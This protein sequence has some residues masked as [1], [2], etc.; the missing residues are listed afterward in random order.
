MA[1]TGTI[2]AFTGVGDP[3]ELGDFEVPDPAP[4]AAVLKMRLANI[5]GSDMHFWR[6]TTERSKGGVPLPCTLGHEGVGEVLKLGEGVTTDRAGEALHVGDR[7]VFAYFHPCLECPT[8]LKGYTNA[9][10]YRNEG[11]MTSPDQW[12][13]FTG[14][15]GQYYYLFPGHTMFKVPDHLSDRM[16]AGINCALSQVIAGLR[17]AGATHGDTVVLQGAG[18]LGVYAAAVAKA[19]GAAKVIAIDGIDE[20]LELIKAFGADAIVDMREYDSAEARAAR[21]RELSGGL[22]ADVTLELVGHA[23]VIPEG[24]EMTAPGGRYVEIGN[25]NLGPR[26]AFDPSVL[27]FGSITIMG[28]IHYLPRDLKAALEFVSSNVDRLPFER[29]LSHTFP[30]REIDTAFREQDT[31]HVTRGALLAHP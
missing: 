1:D 18:G 23:A 16:V 25:I 20:R 27:V 21:V 19:R 22:G 11:R 28:V 6:G 2:A 26:A 8:C 12:P 24:L 14:T 30:L 5:C 31:G 10:P 15:F 7:V 9:C 3:Y 13:H 29:V 4:G 17:Q